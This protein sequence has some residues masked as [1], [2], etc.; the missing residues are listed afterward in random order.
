MCVFSFNLFNA[1]FM[2]KIKLFVL[3]L[4]CMVLYPAISFADD[5]PIP[6]DQ[7]PANVKAFAQQYFPDLKIIYAE[8]DND[9]SGNTYEIRLSDGTKIEFDRKGRWDKVD[10]NINAVPQ[11]LVPETIA[12][13]VKANFPDNVITM[14]D[15]ERYGYEIELSNDLEL[16][17]N[18]RGN[19]L[20]MDD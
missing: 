15:K 2:K 6:V 5:Y 17:F 16:K 14:V 7:L 1:V 13:Y 12:A 9:F 4:L 11:A 19:L 3:A 20:R 18:K 8:K 10:C